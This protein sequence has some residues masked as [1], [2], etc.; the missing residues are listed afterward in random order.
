MEYETAGDPVTGLKWTR[1]TTQK[2]ADELSRPGVAVSSVTVGKILKMIGYSLK[3]NR[4]VISNGGKSLS[5]EKIGRA[6]RA[7]QN[8]A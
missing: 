8:N 5:K 6:I 7:H 2:I 4:K 3:A 1:K